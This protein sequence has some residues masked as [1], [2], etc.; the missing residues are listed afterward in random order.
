MHWL[1]RPMIFNTADW[2]FGAVTLEESI[3]EPTSMLTKTPREAGREAR[4]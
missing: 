2:G 4:S 3:V 1:R